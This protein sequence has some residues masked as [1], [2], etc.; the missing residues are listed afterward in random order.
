MKNSVNVIW[1]PSTLPFY[2]HFWTIRTENFATLVEG[3]PS[4]G[5]RSVTGPHRRAPP[6][7]AAG[8][9]LVCES[10]RWRLAS[11]AVRIRT[12]HLPKR[13]GTRQGVSE[14]PLSPSTQSFHMFAAVAQV[15]IPFKLSSVNLL[16]TSHEV[17]PWTE[18]NS[19]ENDWKGQVATG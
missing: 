7:R 15:G 13:P 18:M 17:G 3:N 11:E 12:D 10:G 2:P 4:A 5:L 1:Q 14:R 16:N 9:T 8:G 6:Y 19:R